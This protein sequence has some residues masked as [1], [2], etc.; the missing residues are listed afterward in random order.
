MF[1]INFNFPYRKKDGS[2]ITTF[3]FLKDQGVSILFSTHITTDLEK[4]A[5]DITYLAAGKMI[6]SEPLA[7]FMAAHA[8]VGHGESLEEIMVYHEKESLYEKLAE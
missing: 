7:D 5:D 6:A 3:L 8:A 4:C 1:P 2:V